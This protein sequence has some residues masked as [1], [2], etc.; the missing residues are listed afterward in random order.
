MPF[1]WLLQITIPQNLFAQDKKESEAIFFRDDFTGTSLRPEWNLIGEDTERW[2]IVDN[3]YL[4]IIATNRSKEGSI[5]NE[6]VFAENMTQNY[7]IIVK[8]IASMESNTR[9]ELKI[10]R[11]ETNDITIRISKNNIN[12]IKNLNGEKSGSI[13]NIGDLSGD[14][15]IKISKKDIYYNGYYSLDGRTWSKIGSEQIFKNL[16]GKPIFTVYNDVSSIYYGISPPEV[17]IK[18]DFFEIRK[19]K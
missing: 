2:A 6:L 5:K 14:M 7:E 1:F 4:L 11:D 13:Q 3:E 9:I 10:K 18:I 16:N 12:F 17:G 15:Y 8:I 19:I